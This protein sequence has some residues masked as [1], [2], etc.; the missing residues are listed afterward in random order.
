MTS[1]SRLMSRYY[2]LS[3]NTIRK[4][5]YNLNCSRILPYEDTFEHKGFSTII[6]SVSAF[7]KRKST[8]YTNFSCDCRKGYGS[9]R[10]T[11]QKEIQSIRSRDWS[12]ST[13]P[14]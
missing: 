8:V 9:I 7:P 4:Y 6:A 13:L 3:M 14:P 10:K 1:I 5:L 2:E 12:L 11:L